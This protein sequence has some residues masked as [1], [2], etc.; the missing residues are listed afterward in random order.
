MPEC[1]FCAIGGHRSPAEIVYEDDETVAFMDIVPVAEGHCLVVPKAHARNVFDIA[2]ESAATT[3][4]AA[5]RVA[6]AV[7]KATRADGMNVWQS[8]E[9]VAGQTVFHFHIHVVPRKNGDGGIRFAG[10]H[11]AD[12]AALRAVA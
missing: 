8:S 9:E 6:Q 5:V 11:R 10:R 4:R 2:L 1:I 3:M 12:P 7:K